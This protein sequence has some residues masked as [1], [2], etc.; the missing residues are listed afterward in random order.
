MCLIF[1]H[2]KEMAIVKRKKLINQK[3][4]FLLMLAALTLV[5]FGVIMVFSASYY[6]AINTTGYKYAYLVDEMKWVAL[7]I[8][9]MI[10]TR[11][12]DYHI[13]YV[14]ATPIMLISFVLLIAVLFIG[15]DSHGAYRWIAVG[16]ITI[17]PGELAKPAAIIYSAYFLAKRPK[18]I[19]SFLDGILPLGILAVAYAGL[20]MLQPN[21]STAITVVIIIAGVMFVAGLKKGYILGGLALG[22]TSILTLITLKPDSEWASRF[23]SFTDPF[24]H[25]QD[26]GWQVAQSL[27]AIG[28]GGIWGLGLGKSVQKNL[29]L[30]EAQNDFI[31][32]IYAEELG[33]FACILLFVIYIFLIWRIAKV[34]INAPDMFGTLLAMGIGNMI[35]AQVILNVAVVTSSMPP[36][37][38][39]LPFVSYGGNAL[40]ITMACTGIVLNISSKKIDENANFEKEKRSKQG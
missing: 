12:I 19:N 30:P 39:A 15:H 24:A 21:L 1:R 5:T 29:Y 36:T 16:P 37:G 4:D 23:S 9:A 13:Y 7:G 32:S 26:G 2:K 27:I 34:A 14:F 8:A 33:L 40:L 17:M 20:I 6:M 22:I 11:Y 31:F 10:V 38:I 28:S 25:L 18:R 35:G 3:Q